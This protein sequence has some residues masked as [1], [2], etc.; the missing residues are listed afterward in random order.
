LPHILTGTSIRFKDTIGSGPEGRT[1]VS[2][3]TPPMSR[4]ATTLRLTP[5]PSWDTC[6]LKH[7]MRGSNPWESELEPRL[8]TRGICVRAVEGQSVPELAMG[9]RR[10]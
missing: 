5:Q 2:A 3:M 1:C 9:C 4:V 7:V 8:P 10:R 6:N